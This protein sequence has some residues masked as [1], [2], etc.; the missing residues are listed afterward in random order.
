MK[1][2]QFTLWCL[3]VKLSIA[4]HGRYGIRECS[5]DCQLLQD[6]LV[7]LRMGLDGF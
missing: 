4:M 3:T 7:G 2:V 5:Y 6:A 1:D